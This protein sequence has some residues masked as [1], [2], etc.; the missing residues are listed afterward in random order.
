MQNPECNIPKVYVYLQEACFGERLSSDRPYSQEPGFRSDGM[1]APLCSLSD[2]KA[3][4][5]NL[6]NNLNSGRKG[7]PDWKLSSSSVRPLDGGLGIDKRVSRG[8]APCL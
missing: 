6:V 7:D 1:Y 4:V 2:S 3:L 5:L 8:Q